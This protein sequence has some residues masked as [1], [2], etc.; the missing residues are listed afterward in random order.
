VKK[1]A[2]A[3]H[4]VPVKFEAKVKI[5]HDNSVLS[6]FIEKMLLPGSIGTVWVVHVGCLYMN[7]NKEWHTPDHKSPDFTY[8]FGFSSFK[9]ASAALSAYVY[10]S[11]IKPVG[12]N[13]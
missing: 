13:T 7:K 5:S 1:N 11:N 12:T 2:I 3:Q 4:I 6:V 9:E 10:E 8:M